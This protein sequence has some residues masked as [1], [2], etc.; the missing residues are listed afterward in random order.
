MN[1]YV[2]SKIV[3]AEPMGQIDFLREKW[4]RERPTSL[5][6]TD[7]RE[8]LPGYK[9]VYPDGYESWSPQGVFETTSRLITDDELDLILR[10]VEDIEADEEGGTDAAKA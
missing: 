7:L 6:H 8:N 10:D 4:K 1:T 5:F 2:A 3:R 9:V